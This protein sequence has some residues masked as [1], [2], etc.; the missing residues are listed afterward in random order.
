MELS[1]ANIAWRQLLFLGKVGGQG[2]WRNWRRRSHGASWWWCTAVSGQ[3]VSHDAKGQPF[4]HRF[5]LF[6][7]LLSLV[8]R[9]GP[10]YYLIISFSFF[11][12]TCMSQYRR[13]RGKKNR[14]LVAMPQ[15]YLNAAPAGHD[16]YNQAI[17]Y[18]RKKNGRLSRKKN[19]E[20]REP[21]FSFS[22]NFVFSKW[23]PL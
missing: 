20:E 4:R 16:K 14:H 23:Y 2:G 18:G 3:I 12:P 1:C 6:D 10:A 15:D 5:V 9:T 21:K 17:K 7:S 11:L 19:K 13:R 22:G 8:H